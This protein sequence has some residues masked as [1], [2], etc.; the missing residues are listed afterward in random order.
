MFQFLFRI[1]GVFALALAVVM[2]VL[3]ITRS[4]T[5][6]ALVMT[7]LGA[8]WRAVNPQTLDSLKESAERV[9]PILWSPVATSVLALP[10]WLVFWSLAMILLWLGMRRS[11]P[12]GR[13]ASR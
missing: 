11:N 10:G 3:D 5:A 9:S 8:S 1:I 12:Y 13:F 4:I 2:A 7:P 6:S